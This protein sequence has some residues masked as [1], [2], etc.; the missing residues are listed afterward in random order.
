MTNTTAWGFS[1]KA[2]QL[3]ASLSSNLIQDL[4]T[5]AYWSGIAAY[6]GE[7]AAFSSAMPAHSASGN[8]LAAAAVVLLLLLC[9][10]TICVIYVTKIICTV[11]KDP[12]MVAKINMQ[13]VLGI[14]C[15]QN[16]PNMIHLPQIKLG[17]N[18]PAVQPRQLTTG[19]MPTAPAG[20]PAIK[21]GDDQPR[22]QEIEEV[23]PVQ[24]RDPG[25]RLDANIFSEPV[26]EDIVLRRANSGG[27]SV[28]AKRTSKY[29]WR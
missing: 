2:Y 11:K 10:Y 29:N 22:F 16:Q 8:Y 5:T 19:S 6:W 25:Y 3:A 23:S 15:Q 26:S 21:N 12:S 14:N 9:L 20:I 28:I 4:G 7:T 1:Q 27:L 17:T 13:P 24:I 18:I